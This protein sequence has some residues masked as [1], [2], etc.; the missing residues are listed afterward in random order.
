MSSNGAIISV[1]PNITDGLGHMCGGYLLY[2]EMKR[3]TFL[4]KKKCQSQ[5]KYVKAKLPWHP[6]QPFP[7]IMV[8]WN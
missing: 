7:E 3:I 8:I 2:I 5:K 1:L 6:L 4:S